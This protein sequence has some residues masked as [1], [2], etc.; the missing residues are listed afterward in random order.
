MVGF[1]VGFLDVVGEKVGMGDGC[2]V[3]GD[4]EVGLIVGLVL[5]V[6]VE[7][8]SVGRPVAEPRTSVMITLNNSRIEVIFVVVFCFEYLTKQL[9][10]R[11]PNERNIFEIFLC[12][13][14]FYYFFLLKHTHRFFDKVFVET[15]KTK[16]KTKQVH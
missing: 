15:K 1:V 4:S 9:H 8:L 6:C 3:V 2:F 13:C 14:V 16:K 10:A 11:N 7:G 12:R 5:G